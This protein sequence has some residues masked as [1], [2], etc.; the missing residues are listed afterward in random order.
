[1]DNC[2]PAFDHTFFSQ[3]NA[4]VG[5]LWITEYIKGG[6]ELPSEDVMNKWIDERLAWMIARTDGTHSH[7]TNIIPFSVHQIDELLQDIDLE[8]PRFTRFKQWLMPVIGPDF[9]DL[10]KRLQAR[11]G[12]TT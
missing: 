7:G 10:T 3:L 9:K 5:A 2:L 4:E 6:I 11:H 1:M 12:I 8:L